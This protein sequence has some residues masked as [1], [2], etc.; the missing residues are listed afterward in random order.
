MNNS[1]QHL[2]NV[3]ATHAISKISYQMVKLQMNGFED[4]CAN[5]TLIQFGANVEYHP[6]SANDE[7][8]VHQ[9]GKKKKKLLYGQRSIYWRRLEKTY[10]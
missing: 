8:R 1:W 3:I 4:Q 2:W 10:S 5:H 6:I 7:T 9:F